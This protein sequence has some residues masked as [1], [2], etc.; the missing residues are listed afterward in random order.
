[1]GAKE[2]NSDFEKLKMG[3]DCFHG[4]IVIADNDGRIIFL[5]EYARN[6][7]NLTNEEAHTMKIHD[8]VDRG[9]IDR[10]VCVEAF[11]TKETAIGCLKT[12]TGVDLDSVGFP[13]LN[14]KGDLLVAA[15]YSYDGQF[16]KVLMEQIENEKKKNRHIKR[17]LKYL[18]GANNKYKSFIIADEKMKNL[19]HDVK[20][21]ARAESNILIYGESG[22][23]KDVMANYIH[24][25]SN[26]QNEVFIPINCG[27]IPSELMEAEFFGYEK[28]A[29]TGANKEG[30]A[31]IF[32]M[33]DKG[34]L[35]LDEI[36]ELPL[37]L[38]AKLLRVLE[39]GEVKRIGSSK[40]IFIDVKIIAATNK[41]LKSMVEKKL[42]REDLYYRLNVIPIMIPPLRQR[43]KDLIELA[44]YFVDEFNKKYECE[45]VLNSDL[46]SRFKSY[47]WPGNIRELKNEIERMVI[48]SQTNSIF[49]SGLN[50]IETEQEEKT[51]EKAERID[52]LP[53]IN[54][55]GE[56]KDAVRVFE[57]N[58]IK[59]AL[60]ECDGKV[61]M[62]ANRLGIHRSVLYKKI[63][64]YKSE[65]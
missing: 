40:P 44:K 27:A 33:V 32:E 2:L 6:L 47:R 18:Q 48:S 24:Q 19:Y 5:N 57:K 63:E 43:P 60:A 10:S 49:I 39:S 28:G 46:I 25:N 42:F 61:A 17:T 13:V 51:R 11:E 9:I 15:A 41:N 31:G 34:T 50:T 56:L 54:Y 45:L 37:S 12:A 30:K 29:F 7:Y 38:Q 22:T 59:A 3:L 53:G 64:Q 52:Y 58:F 1:M 4:N 23:G 35:F 62:A 8:L 26:R 65:E 20:K 36:G 55:K 16:M 21:I 14:E